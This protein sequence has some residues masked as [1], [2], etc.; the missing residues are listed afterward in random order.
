MGENF[1]DDGFSLKPKH[2]GEHAWFYEGKKGL[3]VAYQA[4]GTLQ[5][6]V[7]IVEI[8]WSKLKPAIARYQTYARR[9]ARRRSRPQ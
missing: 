8:P 5:S 6:I 7:G 4:Q 2:L 1:D 3:T 9:A